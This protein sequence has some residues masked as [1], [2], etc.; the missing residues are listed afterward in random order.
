MNSKDNFKLEAMVYDYIDEIKDIFSKG[1]KSSALFD[2]SKNEIL[3][4]FFISRKKTVN[5]SE[6]ADYINAPINTATG[7]INRLEKKN[8]VERRR[9]SDDKRVVKITLTIE[10]EELFEREKRTLLGY[11]M[12]VYKV[13]SDEE[14][15]A[16]INIANKVISVFKSEIKVDSEEKSVKKVK[17]I[18]IE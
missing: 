3:T 7:V 10:G 11:F 9:D 2:F 1:Q 8:I 13:L 6:V 18:I 15:R 12:E 16:A 5:V 17:R 14:K 4:L